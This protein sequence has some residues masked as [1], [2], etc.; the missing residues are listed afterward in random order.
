[1]DLTLFRAVLHS[2]WTK[3]RSVKSTYWT[4]L[5]AIVLGIGLGA[6]ISAGNAHDYKNLSAADKLTFD[7]TSFSTAGLF[8]AQLALGVLAILAI[9][10]EYSTGTIRTTLAAVPQ[11]GYTLAAKSLLV[12]TLSL[13]LA[14]GLS[15]A[16]FFI[17]RPIFAHYSLPSFVTARDVLSGDG[18]LRAV[19]GA[20]LYI[21][22]L[23]LFAIG[24]GTIIRH[25]AGAITALVAVVFIIPIVSNLLPDSWQQHFSNYLPANAGGAITQVVQTPHSLTPWTGFFVF[26]AWALGSLAVG[27]FLLRTRDV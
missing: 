1:M 24:L 4:V 13:I 23:T 7:P 15:F 11:R 27:W 6:A 20:G 18:V 10:S 19:V 14:T 25:T 22:V 12:A 5:S 3:L 2:E 21:G 8:F 16:A 17:C 9:T 26:L